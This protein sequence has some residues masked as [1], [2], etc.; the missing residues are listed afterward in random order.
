[1]DT[2]G[3][4]E[5]ISDGF[6]VTNPVTFSLSDSDVTAKACTLEAPKNRAENEECG[7]LVGEKQMTRGGRTEV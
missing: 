2:Y 1:M 5:S 6:N 7:K 4:K 3:T